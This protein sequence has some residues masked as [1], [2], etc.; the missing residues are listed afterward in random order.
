MKEVKFLESAIGQ[1]KHTI[2]YLERYADED[3]S[4]EQLE[5]ELAKLE[6][7]EKSLPKKVVVNS[8]YF[9]VHY[10]CPCGRVYF[11]GDYKDNYCSVCG[12][13]LDWSVTEARACV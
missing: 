2:D 11:R 7:C 3:S 9:I 8:N 13:L 10:A 1:I 4:G 5:C 12:Q 6:A